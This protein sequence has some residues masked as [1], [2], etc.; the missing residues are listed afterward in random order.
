[1]FSLNMHILSGYRRRS[2]K[3]SYMGISQVIDFDSLQDPN[4]RFELLQIIGEGT[5]GEVF[6]AKDHEAGKFNTNLQ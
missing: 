4:E 2:S 5:Y 1:M 6:S 3:M